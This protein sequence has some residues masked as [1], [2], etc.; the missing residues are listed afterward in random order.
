[1][2]IRH[3]G[4]TYPKV[5]KKELARALGADSV[6]G[7]PAVDDQGREFFEFEVVAKEDKDSGIK[8]VYKLSDK[9]LQKHKLIGEAEGQNFFH[10]LFLARNEEDFR[11]RVCGYRI[12]KPT[13]PKMAMRVAFYEKAA[14]V[15]IVEIKGKI[16]KK[17]QDI[18][19]RI[20]ERKDL[21]TKDSFV[22]PTTDGL[23][24]IYF[25]PHVDAREA[26]QI[27]REFAEKI[28]KRS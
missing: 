28:K 19:R 11:N 18:L 15:K 2:T 1:M 8:R 26:D 17:K 6:T 14:I 20:L 4:K 23:Y 10:C 7:F 5:D 25:G 16:S 3:T 9:E 12:L 24:G 21:P 27:C 22:Y 13:Q